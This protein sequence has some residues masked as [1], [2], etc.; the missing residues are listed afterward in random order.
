MADLGSIKTRTVLLTQRLIKVTGIQ[1][2]PFLRDA[3]HPRESEHMQT[4]QQLCDYFDP[5]E[6]P[7]APE[8]NSVMCTGNSTT[9]G[10]PAPDSADRAELAQPESSVNCTEPATALV[11]ERSEVAL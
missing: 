11:G 10:T 2:K 5:P 8:P 6:P 3:A 4:L 1:L 9:A 7:G